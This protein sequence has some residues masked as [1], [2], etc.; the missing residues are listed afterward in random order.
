MIEFNTFAPI[1]HN[2]II[3]LRGE[4]IAFPADKYRGVVSDLGHL[5]KS[6]CKISLRS[7]CGGEKFLKGIGE[8]F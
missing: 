3:F 5:G 4:Y 7:H 2:F 8:E 6:F 1:F